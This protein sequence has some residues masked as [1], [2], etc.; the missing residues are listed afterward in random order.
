MRNKKYKVR[1]KLSGKDVYAREITFEF[2]THINPETKQFPVHICNI[3]KKLV[4]EKEFDAEANLKIGRESFHYR[5]TAKHS[6]KTEV[7]H[8]QSTDQ[9]AVMAKNNTVADLLRKRIEERNNK[10]AKLMKLTG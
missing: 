4:P 7:I 9:Q 8:T 2:E 3:L 5:F 10:M 1:V 6:I